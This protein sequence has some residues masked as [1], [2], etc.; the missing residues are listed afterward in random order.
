[1]QVSDFPAILKAD[2]GRFRPVSAVFWPVSA[3]SAVSAAGRYARYGRYGPILT[4]S[5]RFGTNRSQFG[6]NRAVSAQIKPSQRESK[7]KKKKKTQMQTDARATA[8]DADEAPLVPH[9]CFLVHDVKFIN[10]CYHML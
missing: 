10:V 6:T 8:S 2:F 7:K 1:M 4:E 5:A 3:V 9:P